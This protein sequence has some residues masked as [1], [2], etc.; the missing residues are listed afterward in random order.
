MDMWDPYIA[1]VRGHV[2]EVG[3]K[4]VFDKFH[5]AKH[6]GEA[7]DRDQVEARCH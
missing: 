5:I 1:S 4:I 2:P 3:G 7:V 6:V